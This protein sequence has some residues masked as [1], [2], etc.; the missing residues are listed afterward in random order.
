[1][2]ARPVILGE[3]DAAARRLGGRFFAAALFAAAIFV[4]SLFVLRADKIFTLPPSVA[5]TSREDLVAFWQ[6]ARFCL[7]GSAASAYNPTA[8]RAG[9]PENAQGL[10][11]LNPPHFFLLIAPLGLISYGAAKALW[12]AASAAA[13]AA[14][15]WLVK[16][17]ARWVWLVAVPFSPA[18]FAS[19]LV[20][21][22]G[23]FVA[24]ALAAALL[25]SRERP[26][27][28]G[29]LLALLTMKPQF[30]LMAPVF[31]AARGDWRAF[32]AAIAFSA[33]LMIASAGVFGVEAW[34]AFFDSLGVHAAHAA[35]IHRDMVTVHQTVGKLGGAEVLRTAA[36][37]IAI[38]LGGVAVFFAARRWPRDAAIG[39]TLLVSAFVSPS[40]WIY[41]WPLAAAG[42]IL[43]ARVQRPW[44][45]HIQS[46]AAL[47]WIAPLIS[48]GMLTMQSS[49]AAPA[50]FAATLVSIFVWQSVWQSSNALGNDGAKRAAPT[51]Q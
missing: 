29:L 16:P 17:P 39:F 20:M 45:V 18:M 12:I 15:A 48:L 32:G 30:G 42:L 27:L 25:L 33:A 3:M 49:L 1:M 7:E 9:L 13:M 38:L 43:L 37:V 23:P 41:D 8:F 19:L 4:A 11:F 21:Q 50:I 26:L 6:A 47:L 28:A 24:V 14:L 2:A 51:L 46:F 10:L 34:R 35:N 5:E 44:P 40:L 31:L 36:Q 22:A